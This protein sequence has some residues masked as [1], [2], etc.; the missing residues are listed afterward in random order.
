MSAI[1]CLKPAELIELANDAQ[2]DNAAGPA[3]LTRMFFS[4]NSF[5]ADGRF[6]IMDI[7]K[8]AASVGLHVCHPCEKAPGTDRREMRQIEEFTIPHLKYQDYINWCNEQPVKYLGSELPW[9]Q[10][11]AGQKWAL[12]DAEK[13]EDQLAGHFTTLNVHAANAM[14]HGAYTVRW[15]NPD[16]AAEAAGEAG[17]A[18][19][20]VVFPRN[21]GHKVDL[22]KDKGAKV[23]G[24]SREIADIGLCNAKLADRVRHASGSAVTDI[25]MGHGTFT[26]GL[27]SAK[28]AENH[29]RDY[30]AKTEAP[31]DG[32]LNF[33]HR[34]VDQDDVIYHG[35][36]NGIRYWT[37]S[38]QYSDREGNLTYY[39]DPG[40]ALFVANGRDGFQGI[41]V[42][43]GINHPE[44]FKKNLTYF[45]KQYGGDSEGMQKGQ[46]FWSRS[47]VYPGRPNATLYAKVLSDALINEIT[48]SGEDTLAGAA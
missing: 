28:N 7:D 22:N 18:K 46:S 39:I 10:M 25:V 30:A 37:Y 32:N 40:H 15:A 3:W 27:Q 47:I 38:G 31:A 23:W 1:N 19:K 17:A 4:R 36:W 20:D 6:R 41:I 29:F 8:H 34:S 24:S 5:S 48:S 13:I 14:K 2:E 42:K 45:I 16:E 26:Y 11:D 35:E 12:F 44:V 43:G 33:S 9:E 21:P